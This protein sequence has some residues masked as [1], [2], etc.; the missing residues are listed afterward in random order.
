M[1]FLQFAGVCFCFMF[2][3]LLE[4]IGIHVN[5]F[6]FLAYGHQILHVFTEI[7]VGFLRSVASSG[8]F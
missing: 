8:F 1:C 2:L 6:L 5:V 4:C 3:F 7:W